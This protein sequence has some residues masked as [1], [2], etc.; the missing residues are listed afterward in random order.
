MGTRRA[1]HPIQVVE[2]DRHATRSTHQA[3]AHGLQSPLGAQPTTSGLE[4]G[5]TATRREL[6]PEVRVQQRAQLDGL[7]RRSFLP[8]SAKGGREKIV[9]AVSAGRYEAA[10]SLA[11]HGR[12]KGDAA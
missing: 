12:V 2:A 9:A 8:R 7:H 4:P 10:R 5:L 6:P 1:P 11:I 3:E